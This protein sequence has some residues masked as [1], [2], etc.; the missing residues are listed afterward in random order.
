MS[1][2]QRFRT[3]GRLNWR[4]KKGELF[5]GHQFYVGRDRTLVGSGKGAGLRDHFP[6]VGVWLD[7][8]EDVEILRRGKPVACLVPPRSAR[9]A[10]VVKIDFAKRNKEIWGDRVFSMREVE[11]MRAFELEGEEG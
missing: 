1:G 4:G 3:G 5:P 9:P 8:G 11:E 10:E 6:K 2:F 7:K